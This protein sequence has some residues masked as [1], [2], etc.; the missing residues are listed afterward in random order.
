MRWEGAEMVQK[1]VVVNAGVAEK[2]ECHH[3]W[4]ISVARGPLSS[5]YCKVCGL[6][7]DF[8]NYPSDHMGM[9]DEF[10]S[11]IGKG[12]QDKEKEELDTGE[13]A[14]SPGKS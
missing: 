6:H 13:Y 8:K 3:H 9:E 11:W 4:V 7:K 2:S 14:A 10:R 12:K 5:G 1:R